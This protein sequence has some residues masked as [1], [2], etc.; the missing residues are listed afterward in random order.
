MPL[1]SKQP[2]IQPVAPPYDAETQDALEL[3]G[4]P[5]SLFR[6]FARNPARARGLAGW[7]HYYLSRQLSLSLRHRELVIDRTVALCG[8]DY[9]WGVHVAAYAERVGLDEEQL[10]SLARGSATDACWD[11]VDRAVIA[12]VDEL[13]RTYDL[14]DETWELLAG[15]LE[16]DGV[17]DLL[18]LAG[19]YHAIA[20]TV[21]A[22]RLPLEDGT[23]GLT[24]GPDQL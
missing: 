13:H 11:P 4:P 8:A 5:I 21:R 22:L 15:H 6:V 18:L 9:E 19:W 16:E 2:R 23:P 12:A 10:A 17:M 1:K 24:A 7:G 14:S 3:L 20:F